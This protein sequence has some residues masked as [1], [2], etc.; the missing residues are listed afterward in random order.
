MSALY[1]AKIIY[2]KII[3]YH[4]YLNACCTEDCILIVNC[5]KY[6]K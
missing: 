4:K 2:L 1:T 5:N 6:A 3:L